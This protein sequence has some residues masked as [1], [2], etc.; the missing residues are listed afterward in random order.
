M[1]QDSDLMGQADCRLRSRRPFVSVGKIEFSFL[2]GNLMVIA[3]HIPTFPLSPREQ[4]AQA[5]QAKP[6]VASNSVTKENDMTNTANLIPKLAVAIG[7]IGSL[8]FSS[9]TPSLA[10]QQGQYVQ[11]RQGPPAPSDL[12][13][14][15]RAP[16]VNPSNPQDL[17]NRSNPQ[18]LTLPGGNNP[19][20]LLNRPVGAGF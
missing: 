19:Q 16:G 17:T 11:T 2:K 10:Y 3:N 14:I 5:Q 9:A 4:V 12:T 20:D 13:T 1:V 7:L 18:D 6:R 8:A 15:G